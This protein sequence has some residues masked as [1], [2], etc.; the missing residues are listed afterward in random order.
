MSTSAMAVIAAVVAITLL[1]LGLSIAIPA[2][3]TSESGADSN[4][5]SGLDIS[6]L[7]LGLAPV[8]IV[9]GLVFKKF[10]GS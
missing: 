10:S 9:I 2:L 7:V 4:Y 1:G 8:G 3:A 6:Y 5:T